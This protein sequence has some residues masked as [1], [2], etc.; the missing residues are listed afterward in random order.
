MIRPGSLC[1]LLLT[2][3]FLAVACA[4][5]S[6]PSPLGA[7][8]K[9]TAMTPATE[10][11][12]APKDPIEVLDAKFAKDFE[13]LYSTTW[14]D[15]AIPAKYKELC[16]AS[17]SVVARCSPCLAYHLKMAIKHGATRDEGV[18]ALRIGVLTGG[19]V[20]IPVAR[21]GYKLLL[22]SF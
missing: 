8:A 5:Q 14:G 4:A 19:S 15:G 2:G 18:E 1:A 17:I 20:T 11:P 16:G 13:H 7:I 12:A 3:N 9:D 22:E 10:A 6:P 21:E